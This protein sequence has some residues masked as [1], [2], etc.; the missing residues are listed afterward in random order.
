MIYFFVQL[1]LGKT[2]PVDEDI[3]GKALNHQVVNHSSSSA[4]EG[5]LS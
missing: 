4:Q 1:L 2:T 3:F 5:V